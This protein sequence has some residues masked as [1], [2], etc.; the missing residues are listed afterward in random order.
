MRRYSTGPVL[1]ITISYSKS[2][3]LN[4]NWDNNLQDLLSNYFAFI[5]QGIETRDGLKEK[6]MLRE[7]YILRY[8]PEKHESQRGLKGKLGDMGIIIV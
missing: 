8:D 4:E 3:E 1:K 5:T 6:K 7:I 2:L